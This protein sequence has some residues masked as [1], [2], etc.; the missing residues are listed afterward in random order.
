[1]VEIS[2]MTL[3]VIYWSPSSN[4]IWVIFINLLKCSCSKF[5]VWLGMGNW[6]NNWTI[7]WTI[8]K[9]WHLMYTSVLGLCWVVFFASGL[10]LGHQTNSNKMILYMIPSPKVPE[11]V[12]HIVP[13]SKGPKYAIYTVLTTKGPKFAIHMFPT[14]TRPRGLR[15]RPMN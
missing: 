15:G 11:K 12:I 14:Q 9:R 2:G 3:L 6:L 13:I 1:M 10:V 5:L 4:F 8:L 7:N